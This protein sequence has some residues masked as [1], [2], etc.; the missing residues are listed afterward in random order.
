MC[1]IAGFEGKRLNDDVSQLEHGPRPD[2]LPIYYLSLRLDT[3]ENPMP[4]GIRAPAIQLDCN[5]AYQSPRLMSGPGTA[6]PSVAG[7]P[8]AGQKVR[9]T[10]K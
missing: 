8:A 5:G 6:P 1:L 9:E 7:H 3:I 10:Y 2:L 4:A